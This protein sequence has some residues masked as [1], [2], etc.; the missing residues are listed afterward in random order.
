M[1]R[2]TSVVAAVCGVAWAFAAP[3]RAVP[4]VTNLASF[5]SDTGGKSFGGLIADSAG[6]LYGTARDGGLY[7]RGTIFQITG[8]RFAVAPEPSSASVLGLL[9]LAGLARRSRETD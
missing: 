5:D 9:G 4:L 1:F 3:A 2:K 8:D 7:D 6:N